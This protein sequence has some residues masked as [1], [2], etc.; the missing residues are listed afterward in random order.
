MLG[1]RSLV[2]AL[3]AHGLT[4]PQYAVLVALLDF[5]DLAPHELAA[6]LQT[7]RSHIS[8]YTEALLQRGYVTRVP[9]ASDRRRVT[10]QLTSNGAELVSALVAAA[11]DSQRPLLAAL[12]DSEQRT[13]RALLMKIIVSAESHEAPAASDREADQPQ[14]TNTH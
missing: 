10:V 5:G 2:A 9:D 4:L 8:S 12:S 11:A 13:L 7:D 1:H 3:K 6:R 14:P